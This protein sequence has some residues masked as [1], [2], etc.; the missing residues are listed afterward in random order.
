MWKMVL[1][2]VEKLSNVV[3]L[4]V[5]LKIRYDCNVKNFELKNWKTFHRSIEKQLIWN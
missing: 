2:N 1:E 4:N 3:G 5:C